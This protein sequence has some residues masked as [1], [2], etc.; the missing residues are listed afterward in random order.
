MT[1]EVREALEAIDKV[2]DSLFTLAK[3]GDREA[4]RV[5]ITALQVRLSIMGIDR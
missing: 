3:Q 1:E 2:I 4:A 5:M